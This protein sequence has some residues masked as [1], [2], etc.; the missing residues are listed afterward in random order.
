MRKQQ[1]VVMERWRDWRYWTT[2]A[3]RPENQFEHWCE[4]INQA[5]LNWSIRRRNRCDSFPA[6][7]R[8]GRFDGC[9]LA[10]MTSPQSGVKGIRSAAEIAKDNE[11]LFSLL[12]IVDGAQNLNIDGREITVPR[13]HF[14]L[15]DTA[16]PMTFVTSEHLR[17]V[18]FGIPHSRLLRV[19]PDAGSYVGRPI[20]PRSGLSRYFIEHL[21]SLDTN[22]GDLLKGDVPRILDATIEL[23]STT[24][25]ASIPLQG[26]ERGSSRLREI[27]TYIDRNLEN[28][29]L[30]P[31]TIAAQKGITVR[32]L[33]RLF[34]SSDT[35]V[36]NWI[37]CRRLERCRQELA[38]P[39]SAGTNITAIA[40]RWGFSDSS[41]FSTVFKRKYGMS[42]RKYR[43]A[44]LK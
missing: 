26:S 25:E 30:S 33:H 44:I 19:L 1:H 34:A 15:W 20:Y 38:A 18:T 37:Q 43:A 22:F 21:L 3:L 32:H 23:L 2:R 10:T 11:A 39:K 35:T 28:P 40:F 29:D 7:I 8:E 42:P 6:Y 14:L 27:Q 9:R 36:A 41:T 16:R 12:Y 5:Y 13:H 31:S 4:F 17:Q 24:L